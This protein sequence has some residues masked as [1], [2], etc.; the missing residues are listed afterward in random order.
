MPKIVSLECT[1]FNKNT[2]FLYKEQRQIPILDF[3][4]GA[5]WKENKTESTHKMENFKEIS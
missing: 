2:T 4:L 1:K 3:I 5:E